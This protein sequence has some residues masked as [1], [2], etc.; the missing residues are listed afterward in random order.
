[1]TPPIKERTGQNGSFFA[2]STV[3][4]Y[5]TAQFTIKKV[6]ETTDLSTVGLRY[7]QIPP[8]DLYEG[9]RRSFLS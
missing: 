3:Y 9:F 7:K 5:L 1:M 6:I 4:V 8:Y 2:D